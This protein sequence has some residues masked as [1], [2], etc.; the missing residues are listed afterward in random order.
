MGKQHIFVS[1]FQVSKEP[2]SQ[3]EAFGKLIYCI[4]CPLFTCSFF[5]IQP[6]S[7]SS[8]SWLL[9]YAS[10]TESGKFL[11]SIFYVPGTAVP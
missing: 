11:P 10:F 8:S 7:L 4:I 5:L 9:T 1:L 6:I 2:M 3:I